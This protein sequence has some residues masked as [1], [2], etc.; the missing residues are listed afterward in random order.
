MHAK[1]QAMK[2]S[3]AGLWKW[4]MPG[5]GNGERKMGSGKWGVKVKIEK[6]KFSQGNGR[7]K[8]GQMKRA[9]ML[10]RSPPVAPAFLALLPFPV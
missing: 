8:M 9:Q 3:V 6:R 7:A 5:S 4:K 2:V 1:R 10:L